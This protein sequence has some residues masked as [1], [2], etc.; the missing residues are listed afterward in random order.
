MCLSSIKIK[1]CANDVLTSEILSEGESRI[2]SLAAFIA[3]LEGSESYSPFI[4]D[5]PISSLDQE[6]EEKVVQRLVELSKS[7]QVIVFTHR[8]S[9]LVSLIDA[10][11]KSN[12]NK[13]LVGLSLEGW[14]TGEPGGSPIFTQKPKAALNTILGQD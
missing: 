2:I 4:F 8:L 12:I 11:K 6:F 5:D 10:A 14:G 13:H 7:R 1:K 9:M 3:D